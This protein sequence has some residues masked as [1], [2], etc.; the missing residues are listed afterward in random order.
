MPW[1]RARACPWST[2]DSRCAVV[3]TCSPTT[4]RTS[5][6]RVGEPGGRPAPIAA[7]SSRPTPRPSTSSGASTRSP[8]AKPREPLRVRTCGLLRRR[9]IRSGTDCS[10]ARPPRGTC[11]GWQSLRRSR[12]AAWARPCSTTACAGFAHTAPNARTSTPKTTTTERS[13]CTSA[14]ASRDCP[15]ACTSWVESCEASTARGAPHRTGTRRDR[16]R[17][18]RAGVDE[19]AHRP[20]SGD[21]DGSTESTAATGRLEPREPEHVGPARADLHDEAAH[22]QPAAGGG[23]Q[24][25]D[26]DPGP[27]VCDVTQRIRRRDQEPEPRRHSVRS[28]PDQRRVAPSRCARRSASAAKAFTR[29]R[30]SS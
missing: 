14:R 24:R 9:T 1:D 26:L 27:P 7:R 29:S 20:G 5:R 6:H 2:W 15:S 25:R 8:C 13:R 18:Q 28:E 19:P 22:R 21:H 23:P 3:C 17:V 10:G 12:D 4:S 30:C 16:D 11:S